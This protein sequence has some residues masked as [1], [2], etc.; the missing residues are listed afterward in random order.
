MQLASQL[1]SIAKQQ[2]LSGLNPADLEVH[3]LPRRGHRRWVALSAI[4]RRPWFW[5]TWVSK[6]CMRLM[7]QLYYVKSLL[8]L[9]QRHQVA[10][11]DTLCLGSRGLRP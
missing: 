6:L 9:F 7:S 8:P 4:L 11:P 1:L 3:G 5:R 10:R 2:P